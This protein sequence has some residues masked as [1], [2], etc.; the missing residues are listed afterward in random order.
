[1]SDEIQPVSKMVVETDGTQRVYEEVWTPEEW[2]KIQGREQYWIDRA[3]LTEREK[4]YPNIADQLDMLF[5][6]IESGNLESGD[7]ITAIRKVKADNPKPD[8]A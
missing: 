8:D 2:Q 5:H 6:D 7:W 3:W 1:M 4:A